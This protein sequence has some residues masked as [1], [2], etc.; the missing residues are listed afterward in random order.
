MAAL[1]GAGFAATLSS[2]GFEVPYLGLALAAAFFPLGHFFFGSLMLGS[3]SI[4]R[5][6]RE[7]QQWGWSG[8]SSPS[9]RSCSPR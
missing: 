8:R 6:R 1:T 3:G 5:S 2:Y 4:G 7:A 9:C